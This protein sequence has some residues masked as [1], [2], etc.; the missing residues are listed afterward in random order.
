M[1]SLKAKEILHSMRS[2]V[3]VVNTFV[4][5]R[6]PIDKEDGDFI[7]ATLS[8]VKKINDFLGELSDLVENSFQRNTFANEK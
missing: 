5:T 4:M 7:K 3:S 1:N 8:S 6:E 2:S